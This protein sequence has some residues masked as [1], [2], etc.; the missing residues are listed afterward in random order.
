MVMMFLNGFSCMPF[1]TFLSA[2]LIGEVG[3][4][5]DRA[6]TAW[7]LIGLV[8]MASGV[9]M[10]ALA[11]RISIR[12]GMVA[13][14][15][16]LSVAALSVMIITWGHLA[17]PLAYV[18]SIAFGLSFY[19]VFG[20]VPAYISH[21][22]GEGDAALVFAFGCVALGLGGIVGNL[23]G[24]ISREL[25]GSF[26]TLYFL[27]LIAALASAIIAIVLPSEVGHDMKG[28]TR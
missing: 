18:A 28:K 23:T 2:F 22:F 21:L 6:A 15:L 25:L 20:L 4:G 11:D 14:Y 24:G 17:V 8:G 27:I 3:F 9:L 7:G 19:A 5:E 26:A 13:T 12:R 1:Q 10:G 16:V